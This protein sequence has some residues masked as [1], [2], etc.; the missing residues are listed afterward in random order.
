MRI[1]GERQRANAHEVGLS[2]PRL[3][4]MSGCP[5]RNVDGAAVKIEKANLAG[6]SIVDDRLE[7]AAAIDGIAVTD[8]LAC[9]QAGHGAIGA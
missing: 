3:D 9:W 7:G 5:V 6:G 8:L 2:S 1:E 4:G